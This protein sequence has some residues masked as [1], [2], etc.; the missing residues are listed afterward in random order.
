MGENS[1]RGARDPARPLEPGAKKEGG[2]AGKAGT[3][4]Q[5]VGFGDVTTGPFLR[6]PP[7]AF[8]DP[9]SRVAHLQA[10]LEGEEA[11]LARLAA[12]QEKLLG[13]HDSRERDRALR[14]A[15][16]SIR[17]HDKMRRR[18]ERAIKVHSP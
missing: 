5:E 7:Y 8:M 2:W 4:P 3:P 1:Q 6:G 15:K 11:M 12:H 16:A 18:L 14:Q 17:R 9:G 10:L 13:Q